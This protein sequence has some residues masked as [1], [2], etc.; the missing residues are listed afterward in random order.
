MTD[1]KLINVFVR[2][3]ANFTQTRLL[4]IE[5]DINKFSHWVKF[6]SKTKTGKFQ[7]KIGYNS[8]GK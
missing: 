4:C 8:A 7:H 2:D 1:E 5:N 3:F 6:V